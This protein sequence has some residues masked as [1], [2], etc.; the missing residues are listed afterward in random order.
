MTELPYQPRQCSSCGAAVEAWAHW[1]ACKTRHKRQQMRLWTDYP[2]HHTDKPGQRAPIREVELVYYDSNKYCD[3]RYKSGLYN[4][5]A[6]YLYKEPDSNSDRLTYEELM[7]FHTP[8]RL[9][10][11]E[12]PQRKAYRRRVRK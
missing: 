9:A 8:E 7:K 2:F 4:F 1:C 10:G 11:I 6:G 12:P 5:K 3:I